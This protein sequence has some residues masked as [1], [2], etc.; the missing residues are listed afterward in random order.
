LAYRSLRRHASTHLIDLQTPDG[1][2]EAREL[3][4][5]AD[6][7]VE[8]FR[9]GVAARLGLGADDLRAAQPQLVYCSISG[10]GQ[11]G[12]WAQAP[13]HDINYE[14]ISG[15]LD[16]SGTAERITLPAVPIADLAGALISATAIC[17][18]LVQRAQSGEGCVIDCSLSEAALSL[19]A[20]HLPA[21]HE[22]TAARAQG[23]L[24]GALAAY[25]PYECADGEWIALG[26]IE[27][28]FFA[29]VCDVLELPQL[30]QAQFDPDRQGEL[31]AGL[32][33]AFASQPADAWR[34]HFEGEDG[35]GC[36]VTLVRTPREATQ[37]PQLSARGAVTHLDGTDTWPIPASPY[38]INGVRTRS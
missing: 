8:S 15:L 31:R 34:Q 23:L 28:K 16:Q 14:A 13:G 30:T 9:P 4:T 5:T 25:A 3:V 1:V 29:R 32:A 7:F 6:V 19:Q 33:A 17:A 21:A 26:P 35:G 22:P 36:C 24:T 12:P 2:A 10:Y 38:V 20:M 27:P 11:T 37:H 18:A